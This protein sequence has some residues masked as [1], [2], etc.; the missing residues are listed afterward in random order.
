MYDTPKNMLIQ[1]LGLTDILIGFLT[2]FDIE[3]KKYPDKYDC[4][5]V[6]HLVDGCLM[7]SVNLVEK[8]T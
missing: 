4:E 5:I 6:E 3:N 8:Y 7:N 2:K 1:L